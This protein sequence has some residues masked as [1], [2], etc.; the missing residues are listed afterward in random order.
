MRKFLSPIINLV[1][2]I[3]VGI[4]FGL[5]GNTAIYSPVSPSEHALGNYYQVIWDNPQP[6]GVIAFFLFVVAV[7]FL[8]ITLIPFKTRKFLAIVAG[9]MLIASAILTCIVTPTV[10]AF[11][12]SVELS[13]SLIGFVVLLNIAGVFSI[14]MGIIELFGLRGK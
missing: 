6:M 11:P 8:V 5:A 14:T 10:A 4:A 12:N 1:N 3:L 13:S 9:L 2:L 7:F